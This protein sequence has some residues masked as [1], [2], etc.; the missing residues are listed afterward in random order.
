MFFKI[1]FI[2][3][4]RKT[5]KKDIAFKKKKKPN[6]RHFYFVWLAEQ[7]SEMLRKM[8]QFGLDESCGAEKYG[9]T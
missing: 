3:N 5:L 6:C 4:C 2:Y 7:L 8:L 9:I 1:D